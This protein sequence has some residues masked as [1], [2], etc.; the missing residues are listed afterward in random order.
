[1]ATNTPLHKT[2]ALTGSPHPIFS[3]RDTARNAQAAATDATIRRL[4][5]LCV[6]DGIFVGLKE[7]TTVIREENNHVVVL[8]I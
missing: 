4:F 8:R 6:F 3:I 1:M 2:V 7:T 5:R